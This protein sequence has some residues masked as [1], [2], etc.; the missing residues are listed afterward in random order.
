MIEQIKSPRFIVLS[1]LVLCAA[2]TRA[3]PFFIPNTWNFTAIGALAIFAGSQFGN[4]RFAF[5]IPV[6]AMAI[7]DLFIGD[8][9]SPIVY[10]GFIVMVACGVFI[11]NNVN[12]T[13]VTLSSIVGTIAFYL[14]TNFAYL[15]SPTLYPHNLTGIVTSYIMA[16]P[17]LRNMLIGD[18]F[19]SLLLFGA[20]YAFKKQYPV[21][22]I[23]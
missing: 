22:T 6:M 14:I 15:Y 18:A 3:L 5:I 8:G 13:S 1:L 20:Y 17:F 11:R 7:A 12:P 23:K 4:S 10:M 19:Y 21:L 9:F 2:L 16:L